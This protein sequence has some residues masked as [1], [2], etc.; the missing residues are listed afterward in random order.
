M[1]RSAIGGTQCA[2]VSEQCQEAFLASRISVAV[3]CARRQNRAQVIRPPRV[4]SLGERYN[5]V[6]KLA[7]A[8]ARS[9]RLMKRGTCDR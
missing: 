4:E 9:S 5:T 2:A 6:D 3:C 7:L 8:R 1:R